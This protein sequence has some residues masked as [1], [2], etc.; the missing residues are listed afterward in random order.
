MFRCFPLKWIRKKRIAWG[1]LY[2]RKCTNGSFCLLIHTTHYSLPSRCRLPLCLSISQG[3][4][5][6]SYPLAISNIHSFEEKKIALNSW[7]DQTGT[8]AFTSTCI[9]IKRKQHKTL[10]CLLSQDRKVFRFYFHSS[11]CHSI[12]WKKKTTAFKLVSKVFTYIPKSTLTYKNR[13]TLISTNNALSWFNFPRKF[14][15]NI[16]KC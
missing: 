6:C 10:T 9:K 3:T 2:S 13:F 8:I 1:I 15:S 14:K 4:P 16:G 7:R 5:F 12:D 11:S